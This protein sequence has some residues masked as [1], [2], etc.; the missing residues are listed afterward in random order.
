MLTT[1]GYQDLD[2]GPNNRE[3]KETQEIEGRGE[4]GGGEN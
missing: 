2:S 4:G 3:I 1:S